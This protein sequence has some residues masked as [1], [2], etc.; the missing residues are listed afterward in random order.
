MPEALK[1]N[2]AL[3]DASAAYD[4]ML[5]DYDRFCCYPGSDME[6]RE[7]YRTVYLTSL[8][9][10]RDLCTVIVERLMRENPKVLE[11]MHVLYLS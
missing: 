3:Q 1:V 5:K 9:N 11:D 8:N 4:K 2:N 7:A 6:I 10:Y